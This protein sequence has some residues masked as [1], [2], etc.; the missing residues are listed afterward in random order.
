MTYRKIRDVTSYILEKFDTVINF[1][2]WSPEGRTYNKAVH[3][4]NVLKNEAI[5]ACSFFTSKIFFVLCTWDCECAHQ[6]EINLGLIRDEQFFRRKVSPAYII[7]KRIQA[8]TFSGL[9][10]LPVTSHDLKTKPWDWLQLLKKI[11]SITKRLIM[12]TQNPNSVD[13]MPSTQSLPESRI[14]L[15][16]KPQEKWLNHQGNNPWL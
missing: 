13:Q 3:F 5:K 8:W 4:C 6:R 15:V 10:H 1:N 11:T 9:A 14:T 16:L 7:S 12:L 2:F